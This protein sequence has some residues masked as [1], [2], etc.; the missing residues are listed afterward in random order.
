[1]D[2]NLDNMSTAELGNYAKGFLSDILKNLGVNVIDYKHN[3]ANICVKGK[4]D[5]FKL[6]VKSIRKPNTGYIKIKKKDIDTQDNSLF[7]A[8]IL[9]YRDEISK[10]FLIPVVDLTG[11][12]DLFRDRDYKGKKS[13]P[14]WGLNVTEKNMNILNQYELSKMISKLM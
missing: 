13:T 9:F 3:E 10:I 11:D 7:I 14:E 5:F 1:M 12:N 8:T 4:A 6:K 2:K